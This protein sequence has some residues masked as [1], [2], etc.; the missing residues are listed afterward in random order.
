MKSCLVCLTIDHDND[1][2]SC[3]FCGEAS[4]SEP[5]EPKPTEPNDKPSLMPS[6]RKGGK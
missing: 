4:F 6:S 1:S 2:A 5:T 3:P